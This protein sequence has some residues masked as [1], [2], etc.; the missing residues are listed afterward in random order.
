MKIKKTYIQVLLMIVLTLGILGPAAMP[1]TGRPVNAHPLLLKTAAES[2]EQYVSVI[3]QVTGENDRVAGAVERLGGRV[4]KDLHIISAFAAEMNAAAAMNIARDPNVR[5]VSLDGKVESA[6]KPVRTNEEPPVPAPENYYLDT[7]G[8]RQTWEMDLDGKGIT[9]AVIDSGVYADNDFKGE[10]KKDPY[11]IIYAISF[12]PGSFKTDDATGHG[13]HVAGIVGGNGLASDGMYAGV[14]PNVNLINLKVSDETGMA[15][16]SDVVAAMQWVYDNKDLYNVRVV[17]ISLNSTVEQSYHT[18]PIDAA[19]EILWFN[20][21]V[22]VASAGNCGSGGTYNAV[23]AAPA[24]DPFI[25]TVGASDEHGTADFTDDT[26]ASFSA[27]ST[28]MDGNVKPDIIAPGKDIV[29]VS[30]WSSDWRFNHPDR[31]VM[32]GEYFRLSGTSMA[33]PVVTGAVALLLQDEPDLTPDQ[34]KYRL[35][36]TGRT[37]TDDDGNSFSYL[38]AYG[39]VTGDTTEAS[40]TG[41][42]ASQLLW[43]GDEAVAWDSVAWNS[44]AWN[45]V[46]WNSVAWN[47]VAWNSVAWNS[48]AWNE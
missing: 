1:S 48:V 22:V 43:S 24:N 19:L 36:N 9:V 7:T 5:W 35:I 31:V 14:A 37:I 39:A 44:V 4:T 26:I 17:N 20:G 41:T 2:P 33:A 32:D 23:N 46:A 16:E 40:N 42:V 38:D 25:I 3:V 18:S 29:S 11:R 28:T 47:S 10:S 15:Y 27:F 8:V 45:S 6:G 21:V 34:V 30:A 13:T 12:S